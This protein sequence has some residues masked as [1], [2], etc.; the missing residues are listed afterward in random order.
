MGVLSVSVE[1]EASAITGR[2][3]APEAGVTVRA[4]TG[5][6]SEGGAWLLTVTAALALVERPPVSVTM[7]VRV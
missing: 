2:G 3:D 6:A 1:V 5:G 7:T 4:A